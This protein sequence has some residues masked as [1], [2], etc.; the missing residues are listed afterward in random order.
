M[1]CCVLLKFEYGFLGLGGMGFRF[2]L[3]FLV[4]VVRVGS[5]G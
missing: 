3:V 1:Y 2:L 5:K 4:G